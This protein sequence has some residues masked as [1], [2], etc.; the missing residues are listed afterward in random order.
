MRFLWVEKKRYMYYTCTCFR[1]TLNLI[2]STCTFVYY[3]QRT[4][5]IQIQCT[6]TYNVYIQVLC[7][8]N[9]GY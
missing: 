8:S 6:C 9:T 3:R 1:V 4:V 7:E 2:G 5:K